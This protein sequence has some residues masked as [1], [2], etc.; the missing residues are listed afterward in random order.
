MA[1]L[2]LARSIPSYLHL[3][4]IQSY[5]NKIDRVERLK[6]LGCELQKV[7]DSSKLS[8]HL[9]S[10]IKEDETVT[11][12]LHITNADLNFAILNT[13]QGDYKKAHFIAYGLKSYKKPITDEAV[14]LINKVFAICPITSIDLAC[15]LPTKPNRANLAMF[16]SVT[17]CFSS[18][19]LNNPNL[20]G[21]DRVLIYDKAL[22]DGLDKPIWRIEFRLSLKGVKPQHYQIPIDSIDE[23][24]GA[25]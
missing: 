20:Y 10:K 11:S 24:L 22:K 2:V 17:D 9:K 7:V 5:C 4:T 6:A 3:D 8:K 18:K 1:F 12:G 25:M 15:D 13:K 23:V 16:G 14:A 19:Y 21:V